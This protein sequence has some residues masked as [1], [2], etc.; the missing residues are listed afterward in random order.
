VKGC[1]EIVTLCS[2]PGALYLCVLSF[3]YRAK[4]L[5]HREGFISFLGLQA[6]ENAV[7]FLG[8]D[9]TCPYLF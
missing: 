6:K 9:S 5:L 1:D 3:G 8:R 2:E 7:T 4:S